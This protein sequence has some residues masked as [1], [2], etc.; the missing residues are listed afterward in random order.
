VHSPSPPKE[1]SPRQHTSAWRMKNRWDKSAFEEILVPDLFFRGSLGQVTRGYTGLSQYMDFIRAA[2]RDFTNSIK[3]IISEGDKAFAQ[4]MYTGTH[5]G[6]IPE[7]HPRTERFPTP[8]RRCSTL[9]VTRSARS[10]CLAMLMD[11]YANWNGRTASNHKGNGRRRGQTPVS[12]SPRTTSV[13][14]IRFD[15]N[16]H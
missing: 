1:K 16:I 3:E 12:Q 5:E 6:E 15:C 10:G 2:F 7:W 14:Q 8:G 9:M 4:L 13:N 11:C